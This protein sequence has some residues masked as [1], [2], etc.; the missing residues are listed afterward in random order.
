MYVARRSAGIGDIPRKCHWRQ[1]IRLT[2]QVQS[3][4]APS[5]PRFV[6]RRAPF[7]RPPRAGNEVCALEMTAS[8]SL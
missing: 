4:K 8:R 6:I 1:C 7:S 2:C 5:N 3:A